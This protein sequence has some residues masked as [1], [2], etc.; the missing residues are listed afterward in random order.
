MAEIDDISMNGSDGEAE[1][2]TA[3]EVLKALE[4]VKILH[5]R[6]MFTFR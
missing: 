1:S 2:M 6:S 4:E 3:A 5:H